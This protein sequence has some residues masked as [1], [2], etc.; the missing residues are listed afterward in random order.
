VAECAVIGAR[1][2]KWEERPVLLAV[3]KEGY[4]VTKSDLL[5]FIEGKV[6]KW[7][8]PDDVLFVEALPHTPTGKLLKRQLREEFGD[9]LMHSGPH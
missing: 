9:V 3:K 4:E 6:A 5:A 1:H 7:W 8:L 2:P